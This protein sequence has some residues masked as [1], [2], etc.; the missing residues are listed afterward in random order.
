MAQAQI[1]QL[2]TEQ[3][4]IDLK[5]TMRLQLHGAGNMGCF[6]QKQSEMY[7]RYLVEKVGTDAAS[8]VSFGDVQIAE[9]Q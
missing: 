2:R 4:G 9:R 7:A 6:Q 8:M 1:P 3:L 5:T